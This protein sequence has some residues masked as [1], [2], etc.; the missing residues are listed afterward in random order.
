[1]STKTQRRPTQHVHTT[2]TVSDVGFVHDAAMC[3]RIR[4]LEQRV[5]DLE[6]RTDHC[7]C[8]H[9]FPR[10]YPQWTWTTNDATYTKTLDTTSTAVTTWQ[11]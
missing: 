4:E 2:S 3:D 10:Y 8:H 7:G 1:M 6:T 5:R 9:Y 11:P